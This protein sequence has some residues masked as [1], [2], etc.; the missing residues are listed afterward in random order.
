MPGPLTAMVRWR[1]RSGGATRQ[2]RNFLA[3]AYCA[4]SRR[5]FAAVRS[6][7]QQIQAAVSRSLDLLAKTGPSVVNEKRM[8]LL[9]SSGPAISC[10]MVRAPCGDATARRLPKRI[11]SSSILS[12][13][14]PARYCSTVRRPPARLQ[15]LPGSSSGSHR[16]DSRPTCSRIWRS[17]TSRP[18]RWRMEAGPSGGD[19]LR[20][21]TV[22]LPQRRLPY[23]RST[24]TDSPSRRQE[25]QERI[26][27]AGAWLAKTEPVSSEEN[28]MRLL[29]LVWGRAP[30]A[31]IGKAARE[32]ASAQ[33]ADGGW[34]Q[35][36]VAAIGCLRHRASAGCVA[37]ERPL[38]SGVARIHPGSKVPA[39]HAG[40]GRLVARERTG[41]YPSSRCLKAASRMGA[42]SGFPPP[43]R[44][45]RRWHSRLQRHR[46]RAYADATASSPSTCTACS[47]AATVG[48]RV[49]TSSILQVRKSSQ[50]RSFRPASSSC[51]QFRSNDT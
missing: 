46:G 9:P 27:R 45:G 31:V 37:R 13:N 12:C 30:R 35:L 34:A 6:G 25:F 3:G 16:M 28:A 32:L 48:Y 7:P 51:R 50:I 18:L 39:G 49:K 20:W 43:A 22:R 38:P 5:R 8:L 41:R 47:A 19:G 17:I 36:P 4:S 15:R 44:V 11:A 26:A 21:N 33:R 42:T 40:S 29:G 2:S 23:G 1:R 24:F 10:R 14:V